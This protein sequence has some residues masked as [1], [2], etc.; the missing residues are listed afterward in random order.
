MANHKSAAKASRRADA[1]RAQNMHYKSTMRTKVKQ[2]RAA[3][4]ESSLDVAKTALKDA[5]RYIDHVASKGVI[6]K[7]A[8]SRK[9]SRLARAVAGLEK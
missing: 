3:L 5:V 7:R 9:I 8:A 4:A 6:H 1:R 2:V